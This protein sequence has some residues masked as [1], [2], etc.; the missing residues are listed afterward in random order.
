MKSN[1]T[2]SCVLLAGC[3]VFGAG[4]CGTFDLLAVLG[5]MA[6]INGGEASKVTAAEWQL[7]SRTAA[8]LA[9]SPEL[10]L[11]A[12]QAEALAYF[13]SANGIDVFGERP[14]KV[15]RITRG[16]PRGTTPPWGVTSRVEEDEPRPAKG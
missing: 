12:S 6:K 2:A 10:A 9:E 3:L 8:D 13:L 4:G 16:T 15:A 7:L 5:A 14:E 1:R 11:T